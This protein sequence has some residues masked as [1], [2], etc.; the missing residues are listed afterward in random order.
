MFRWNSRYQCRTHTNVSFP[1]ETPHRARTQRPGTVF[2]SEPESSP[3]TL[4]E[5]R[6]GRAVAAT[7]GYER[8]GERESERS[9]ETHWVFP[10]KRE[11]SG[12]QD[13]TKASSEAR[14]V[15]KT[16]AALVAIVPFFG[17][18]DPAVLCAVLHHQKAVANL[19][20]PSVTMRGCHGDGRPALSEASL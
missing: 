1:I 19:Q 20:R 14:S 15:C 12:R 13:L 4:S 18:L 2:Q 16:P 10:C 7:A 11:K 8:E 5:L 3:R 9:V 6:F 17:S